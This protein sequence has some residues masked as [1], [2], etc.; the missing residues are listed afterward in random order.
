M[1]KNLLDL[2]TARGLSTLRL[3]AAMKE[4][5]QKVPAS[6]ITRIEK[7]DRRVDVDDLVAFALALNVAPNALLLPPTWSDEQVQ[8]APEV[9]LSAKTAWLWA[10]GRAPA[11]SYGSGDELSITDDTDEAAAAEE[12]EEAAYWRQ[13][14][15][16]E[17]L[18]HPPQRRRA[19][20]HG[21]NRAAK[22]TATTVD[23]LVSAVISGDKKAATRRLKDA[24]LQLRQLETE[25]EKIKLELGD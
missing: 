9:S 25:I 8:L 6:G 22:A 20:R 1:A 18:T 14:E 15:E 5:G 17:A 4:I 13:R 10:E 12:A 21:A 16:Y 24:E 3:S 7:G 11:S 19:A 2:R 23:G